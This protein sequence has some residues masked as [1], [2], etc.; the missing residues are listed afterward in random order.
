MK[1]TYIFFYGG[2]KQFFFF[3]LTMKLPIL[4]FARTFLYF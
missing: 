3:I 2:K 4:K 1:K